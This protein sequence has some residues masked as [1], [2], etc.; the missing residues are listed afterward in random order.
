[1]LTPKGCSF[2]YVNKEIQNNFDPVIISWGYNAE[3]P[4]KSLFLDYHQQQ[5]TRDYSAFLNCS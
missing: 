5:G 3:S 4:G 2:L 1:M